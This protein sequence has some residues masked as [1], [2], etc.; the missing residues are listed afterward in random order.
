MHRHQLRP[1]PRNNGSA[2][3]AAAAAMVENSFVVRNVNVTITEKDHFDGHTVS[4]NDALRKGIA[5]IT[6][7]L[8][9]HGKAVFR[10]C[11]TNHQRDGGLR[12]WKFTFEITG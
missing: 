1:V 7:I 8:P 3:V 4:Y 2:L 10:R 12:E 5:E 6:A 11:R 9:A